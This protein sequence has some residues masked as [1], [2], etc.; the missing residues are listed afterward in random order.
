MT[1]FEMIDPEGMLIVELRTYLATVAAADPTGRRGLAAAAVGSKVYGDEKGTDAVAPYVILRR[2]GPSRRMPRAPLARFRF[3][4]LAFGR[5]YREASTVAGLVSDC[6]TTKGPRRR[7]AG[8]AIYLST[9]ELG[10]QASQDPD[11][12]EPFETG[13]YIVSVP[14]AQAAG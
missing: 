3:A 4:S 8:V 6:W 1:S 10:G 13:I 14:L 12:A 11:T 2:V 7:S 9:E 5:D